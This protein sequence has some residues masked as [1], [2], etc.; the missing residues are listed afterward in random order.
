MG[1]FFTPQATLR[2]LVLSGAVAALAAC[3]SSPTANISLDQNTAPTASEAAPV[4]DVQ[5]ERIKWSGVK[6]G[7]TGECPR[8]EIDSI[9]FPGNPKLTQLVDNALAYMTGVDDQR[10]GP[11]DTLSEYTKYFWA[12]AHPRDVTVF[13][14]RVKDAVGDIIAIE[15]HTEQSL[16]GAAHSIPATQYMN[17]QRSKSRVMGLEEALIAGR[18]PQFDA[19]LRATHSKWLAANPDAK[20]D[21][22]AYNRMWPFQDS[23]NYALTRDGIVIKYDAYSIAPYSQGEPELLIPYSELQGILKPELIPKS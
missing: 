9:A 19:A 18:K 22:S 12:T 1:H 2:A 15:L 21:P 20:R 6:P 14:A 11:Y 10:R 7:C 23:S 13:K 4:G 17:W 8:I 3:G 16:T 5:T